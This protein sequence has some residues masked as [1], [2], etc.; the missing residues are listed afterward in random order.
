MD[1][2]LGQ[3]LWVAHSQECMELLEK[4]KVRYNVWLGYGIWA[5]VMI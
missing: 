2:V 1:V 3:T 5:T 4:A